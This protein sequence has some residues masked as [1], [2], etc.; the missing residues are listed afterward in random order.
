MKYLV[1]CIL[2]ILF[3][4]SSCSKYDKLLKSDD[5]ELKYRKALYYYFDKEDYVKAG[6]LFE[7]IAPYYRATDKI[8][9]I[10]Y[11]QA[12][13]TYRQGDYLLAAYY[14]KTLTNLYP[15]SPF[16]EES[17]YMNGYCYYISS[18]VP[19]LDQTNTYKAIEA[20]EIYLRKY[21][22]NNRDE[23]V[24]KFM[25]ELRDKL[26]EKS[27]KNAKLYFDLEQY[28]ASLIALNNSLN[29]YPETRYR[30]DILFLILKSSYL[31]AENSVLA[32]R[33]DRY[34]ATIDAYY[35][36]ID[37]YPRSKYSSEAKDIYS[38][39]QIYLNKR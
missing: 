6:N 29:K 11:Y 37:E 22:G 33:N 7:N 15:N 8:D 1:I 35:S 26:V 17:E 10:S 2:T 25:I 3:I 32:K 19:S 36:F 23:E 12:M 28:K 21:E 27:W 31:L 5:F 39:T 30:E 9:T 14:F 20:F 34:Q 16:A 18:P 38:R 24:K 4:F 13:C